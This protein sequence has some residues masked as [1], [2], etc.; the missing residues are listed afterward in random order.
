MQLGNREAKWLAWWSHWK[1]VAKKK[2]VIESSPHIPE[3][4]PKLKWKPKP[5]GAVISH[6]HTLHLQ[7]LHRGSNQPPVASGNQKHFAGDGG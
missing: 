1:S 5:F 3:A 2:K 6:S 4:S 7:P